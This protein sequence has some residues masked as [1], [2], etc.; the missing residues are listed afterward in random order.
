[1]RDQLKNERYF[2]KFIKEDTKRMQWFAEKLAKGEVQEERI[3]PVKAQVHDLK[4]GILTARYSKGEPISS[5]REDFLE[6]LK[7]WEEVLEPDYYNK[8]LKMISL[9]VLFHAD[10][11]ALKKIQA[12]LSGAGVRDWL[13]DFLLCSALGEETDEGI[14]LLFPDSLWLLK[15]MV[16]SANRTEM[17]EK[18]LAGW[19]NEDC[20]CYKAHESRENIYYGYWSFEAGAMARI[21]R[22]DDT[23]LR[24]AKYYPYDLVHYGE[25]NSLQKSD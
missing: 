20:G 24:E 5:L 12:M 7:E 3:F 6:L 9:A 15:E 25:Q 19:Y 17:L 23:A 16:Y 8:N 4:L 11:D 1:M 2:K 21:L 22:L 14:A 10:H 18:Y 13:F